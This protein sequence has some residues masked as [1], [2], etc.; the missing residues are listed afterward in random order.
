MPDPTPPDRPAAPAPSSGF[1]LPAE[2]LRRGA[3]PAGA[4]VTL[5]RLVTYLGRGGRPF[6]G[7]LVECRRCGRPHRYP[8]RWDWGLSADVVSYQESR[9]VRGRRRPRWLALD[10][11]EAAG[12][13]EVH[14]AAQEAYRSWEVER[15]SRRALRPGPP[16]E[17]TR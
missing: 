7:V 6:V 11:A 16:P 8:W 10:P 4:E 15:A 5:G 9:C 14:G 2:P 3:V 12:N 1:D 13:A 17:T